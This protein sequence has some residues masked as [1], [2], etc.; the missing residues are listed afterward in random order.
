MMLLD[1][2][3]VY[4][5]APPSLAVLGGEETGQAG[6]YPTLAESD[7]PPSLPHRAETAA[8]HAAQNLL[9]SISLHLSDMR[10]MREKLRV[11][12]LGGG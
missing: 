4:V 11:V 1:L 8:A 6:A 7:V 5:W 12:R 3:C 2:K 9:I 10:D